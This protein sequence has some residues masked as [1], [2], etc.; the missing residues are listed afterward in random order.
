[1][2]NLATV[3]VPTYNHATR[4]REA[5]ESIVQQDIFPQAIVLVGDDA[6]TDGTYVEALQFASAHENIHV[7]RN[8]VNKGVLGNYAN[9]A[10]KVTTEFVA[11]LEGDDVW[12]SPSKLRRQIEFLQQHPKV[13]V[14]FCEYLILIESSGILLRRPIW[15]TGRFRQL[16]LIDLIY[17]STSSFSTCCYRSSAFVEAIE[18]LQGSQAAD[19]LT[20]MIVGTK[21]GIGFVPVAGTLYR[22]HET[23]QWSGL[24]QSEKMQVFARSVELAKQFLPPSCHVLLNDR[25]ERVLTGA[26]N[27]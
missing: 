20:N 19:W 25:I 9:L 11:V 16:D 12:I 23:G 5:L 18:K 10:G 26:E 24:Q 22:V 14:C 4:I 6:S 8:E 1:M 17:E 13:N 15:S 7:I 27:I 2:S 3:L 21:G